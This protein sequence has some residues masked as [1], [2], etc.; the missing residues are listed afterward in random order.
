MNAEPPALTTPQPLTPPGLERLVR[1]CLAKAPD[2]RSDTAHDVADELRWLCETSGVVVSTAVPRR[3]WRALRVAGLAA[4]GLALLLA[5]TGVG[6]WARPPARQLLEGRF[7]PASVSPDDREVVGIGLHIEA[8]RP[9]Y[10]IVALRF[11]QDHPSAQSVIATPATERSPALSP[12]G[13]WLAYASDT[14]GR[15]EVYLRPHPGPGPAVPLSLDGGDCPAWHPNGH[16]VFFLSPTGQA[17]LASMMTVEFTP[18]SPPRIGRPRVLYT[19]DSRVLALGCA[20]IRCYD[21]APDGERFYGVQ[22]SEPVRPPVVT[23]VNLIPNWFE[24]LKAKVP[25]AR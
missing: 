13:R 16:E 15:N 6:W 18:G 1:R 3:R 21:V 20:P 25:V 17:G 4:G 7:V 24:E 12:D 19:Y 22:W 23:H 9:E 11:D 2:D 10:D 8:W 14:S 5:A